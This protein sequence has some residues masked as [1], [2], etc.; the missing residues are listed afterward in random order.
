MSYSVTKNNAFDEIPFNAGIL[1]TEFDPLTGDYQNENII[2]ATSGGFNFSDTITYM[3]M[4]D[5]VDGCDKNTMELKRFDSREIKAS[6][7]FVTVN[8]ELLAQLMAMA[9]ISEDKITPRDDLKTTDFK[10]LWFVCEYGS[11]VGGFFAIHMMNVLST[12]GLNFQTTDKA[13]TTFTV[14]F[15]A[16]YSLAEPGKVPYEAHIKAGTDEAA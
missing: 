8:K 13:K 4:G 2:G 9:D 14:E 1:L 16:H 15:T 5:G 3:D 11:K 10:D 12:G 7:T 6:G